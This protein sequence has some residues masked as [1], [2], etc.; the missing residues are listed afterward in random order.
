MRR[1]SERWTRNIKKKKRA[2]GQ[3][4]ITKNNRTIE[5]KKFRHITA[6]CTNK[7]CQQY[8]REVQE[9]IFHAFYSLADKETQE[10]Y[11]MKC[12]EKK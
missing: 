4:N 7:C 8:P 11:L 9:E 6:C 3:G 12:F 2:Q 10:S 1:R 5:P